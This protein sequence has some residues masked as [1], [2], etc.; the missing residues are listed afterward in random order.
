MPLVLRHRIEQP[1]F[2]S[3]C[4]CSL[5]RA[6]TSTPYEYTNH[7]RSAAVSLMKITQEICYLYACMM[8]GGFHVLR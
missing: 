2:R 6:H 5:T 1:V 8:A 4:N 3:T 7:E